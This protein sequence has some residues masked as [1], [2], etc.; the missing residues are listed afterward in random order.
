[1][2]SYLSFQ[3]VLLLFTISCLLKHAY[4]LICYI[5]CSKYAH[6]NGHL[7]FRDDAKYTK[8]PP[9][10]IYVLLLI[11]LLI[12]PLCTLVGAYGTLVGAYGTLVGACGTLVGAYGT[13]VGA[14]GTLVG[15]YGTLVG[16]YVNNF[17]HFVRSPAEFTAI[18]QKLHP[19]GFSLSQSFCVLILAFL[20]SFTFTGPG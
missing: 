18:F 10:I 5:L 8:W 3:H 4:S 7:R 11:Y 1:M 14:Y 9:Y 13:L 20:F 2:S 19:I 6:S 15:A 12:Y 17:R 16:A